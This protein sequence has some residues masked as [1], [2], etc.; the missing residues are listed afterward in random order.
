MHLFFVFRRLL[1]GLGELFRELVLLRRR[2]RAEPFLGLSG[3]GE[4][5]TARARRSFGGFHLGVVAWSVWK[6][7]LLAQ[8]F[9]PC[10]SSSGLSPVRP[11]NSSS[12]GLTGLYA[13]L[14]RRIALGT[15][16]P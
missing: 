1:S 3:D 16:V 7:A 10:S 6:P 4:E 13:L 15:D 5:L 12:G 8:P 11:F 14:E 2:R 9:P